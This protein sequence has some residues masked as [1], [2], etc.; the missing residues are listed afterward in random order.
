MYPLR[1]EFSLEEDKAL[2]LP[3]LPPHHSL[4][5]QLQGV[6]NEP[7]LLPILESFYIRP[8]IAAGD[9]TSFFSDNRGVVYSAG[10]NQFGE[11][12]RPTLAEQD[13]AFAP[14]QGLPP[15]YV[16]KIVP[17]TY[18]T[19]ILLSEG[20]KKHLYLAGIYPHNRALVHHKHQT[21][22]FRRVTIKDY[23][24]AQITDITVGEQHCILQVES[25]GTTQLYTDIGCPGQFKLISFQPALQRDTRI[26]KIESKA[27]CSFILVNQGRQ[28]ILYSAGRNNFGQLGRNTRGRSDLIFKPVEGLRRDS[29]ILFFSTHETHTLVGAE[30]N[31]E[32][33]LYS[34]GHNAYG[35][36][37]RDL[38]PGED[39]SPIFAKVTQLLSDSVVHYAL[40]G[41]SCSY[42]LLENKGA[43]KLYSIGDDRWS[44]LGHTQ[45]AESPMFKEIRI[46]TTEHIVDIV[47]GRAHLLILMKKQNNYNLYSLGWDLFGQLGRKRRLALGHN[48]ESRCQR[49]E[50][51]AYGF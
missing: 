42:V 10:A 6:L 11:L 29:R 45:S 31:K 14:V 39:A 41:H 3:P 51:Q 36:L 47:V 40:T 35:E 48:G 24:V 9:A 21:P 32:A 49:I 7:H 13:A 2:P 12:G 19:F 15:F 50:V 17:G 27:G 44:Q 18:G 28:E 8:L 23:P 34:T 33:V 22:A 16:L 30:S 5:T 4:T 46:P 1:Q 37:G 38:L 20:E 26:C 25:Q 43:I